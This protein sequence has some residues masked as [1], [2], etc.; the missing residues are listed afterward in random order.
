MFKIKKNK[1][2][3]LTELLATIIILG[4]ITMIAIPL[5]SSVLYK[6]KKKSFETTV[7]NL[8]K[9]INL[10]CTLEM[11]ENNTTQFQYNFNTDGTISDLNYEGTLKDG[12]INV[13]EKCKI[14][15]EVTD[16]K[17]VGEKNSNDKVPNIYDCDEDGCLKYKEKILNGANP[18]LHEGLI[19]I[20]IEDINN[21]YIK[22]AKKANIK[23][24]WYKYEDKK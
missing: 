1:G 13:N 15:Y 17:F 23:K 11:A 22:K 2:F 16:G 10:K 19:P 18:L 5:L 9:K 24:E 6:F 7:L 21:S 4:L 20:K 3:T 12:E 14:I 8:E